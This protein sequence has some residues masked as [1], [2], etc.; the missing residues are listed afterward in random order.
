[1]SNNNVYIEL[2]IGANDA[3]MGQK[4]GPIIGQHGINIK[5]FCDTFNNLTKFLYKGLPVRIKILLKPNKDFEIIILGFLR[6]FFIDF[7]YK[8][9]VNKISV[10]DVYKIILLETYLEKK[11]KINNKLTIKSKV[12]TIVKF[13]KKSKY[14]I[15]F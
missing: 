12:I 2:V 4:F 10:K 11:L 14:K 9:N 1:M 15:I 13:L 3:K 5:L 7:F 6:K 8:K